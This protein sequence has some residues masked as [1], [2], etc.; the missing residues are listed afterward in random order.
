MARIVTTEET[1]NMMKEGVRYLDV[2][3]VEEFEDGHPEGAWNIPF[4]VQDAMS[5]QM[6]MNP[7]FIK[8]V[9]A[10]FQVDEAIIIGCQAGGRSARAA[11]LLE[12]VGF[13]DL[14]DMGAGWGGG[15]D[16][17][18]GWLACGLPSDQGTPEDRSHQDLKIS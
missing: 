2:R 3:S 10:H 7:M 18:P 9:Q 5:G 12:Q 8:E 6:M 16:G 4:A 11:M 15:M 13:A 14:M 1:E 17:S